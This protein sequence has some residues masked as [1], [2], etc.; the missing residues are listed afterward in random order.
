MHLN[1]MLCQTIKNLKSYSKDQKLAILKY[2]ELLSLVPSS[3]PLSWQW[4][5]WLKHLQSHTA[6]E[7]QT[8]NHKS[9]Q[10]AIKLPI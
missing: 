10:G 6:L 5:E 8:E 3:V 1:T 9:A 4:Q 2:P 7:N